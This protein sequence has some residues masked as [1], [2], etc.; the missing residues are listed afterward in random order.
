L[1]LRLAPPNE[2]KPSDE[3][4]EQQSRAIIGRND[5]I[6]LAFVQRSNKD[7]TVTVAQ[8]RALKMPRRRA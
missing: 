5:P 6:A 7:Q 1:I 3:V 8:V 2:P 4:I